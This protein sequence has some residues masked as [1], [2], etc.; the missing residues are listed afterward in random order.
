MWPLVLPAFGVLMAA[1]VLLW[2]RLSSLEQKIL[3]PAE[4]KSKVS[5]PPPTNSGDPYRG[6]PDL[7]DLLDTGHPKARKFRALDFSHTGVGEWS[8]IISEGDRHPP[9][10]KRVR[11]TEGRLSNIR[12]EVWTF[13]SPGRPLFFWKVVS[14]FPGLPHGIEVVEGKALSWE[15]AM[16]MADVTL[17]GIWRLQRQNGPLRTP[18]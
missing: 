6:V 18:E 16:Y 17:V 8:E 12:V 15:E 11:R 7:S 9:R 10:E 5:L 14:R 3:S 13:P 4:E 2:R 1:L